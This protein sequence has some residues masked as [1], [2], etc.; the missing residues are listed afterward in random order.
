M[1]VKMVLEVKF[2]HHF[3][4][5]GVYMRL[6]LKYIPFYTI[7]ASISLISCKKD[8]N[9]N[10][11]TTDKENTIKINSN[12]SSKLLDINSNE[13]ILEGIY[14]NCRG[15]KDGTS[16]NISATKSNLSV[17]KDDTECD[18][19]AT[20]IKLKEVNIFKHKGH[21]IS[22]LDNPENVEFLNQDK[23]NDKIYAKMNL[24]FNTLNLQISRVEESDFHIEAFTTKRDISIF[25][26]NFVNAPNIELKNQLNSNFTEEHDGTFTNEYT[27]SIQFTNN[28]TEGVVK[29]ALINDEVSIIDIN[30][31][32][33]VF[34]TATKI[35]IPN[36]SKINLDNEVLNFNTTFNKRTDVSIKTIIFAKEL[37]NKTSYHVFTIVMKLPQVEEFLN[38]PNAL[39]KKQNNNPYGIRIENGILK[40][41]R[42]P[43]KSLYP[44]L[45][46]D[47]KDDK[48]LCK[49]IIT[50]D[51]LP[52]FTSTLDKQNAFNHINAVACKKDE[53][54]SG[55]YAIDNTNNYLIMIYKGNK[56]EIVNKIPYFI[57]INKK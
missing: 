38:K 50:K 18:L 56:E 44:D 7:C 24:D 32:A 46:K 1:Q 2:Q 29:Y 41:D 9:S 14:N 33:N 34:N 6:K 15:K 23:N 12:F 11:V 17:V 19:I 5:L 21:T 26:S 10:Q 45:P 57:K 20:K 52:I 47:G 30:Q 53:L 42:N 36:Q 35:T 31:V 54:F 28:E 55:N 27:G 25:R 22:N 37:N 49:I 3:L 16:W 4:F 8:N 43:F 51:S 40:A 39:I 48:T 13:I